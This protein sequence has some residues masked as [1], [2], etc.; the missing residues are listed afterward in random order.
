MG[1]PK[2][3]GGCRERE[4]GGDGREMR[5]KETN[6]TAFTERERQTIHRSCGGGVV[7]V[8]GALRRDWVWV[9][10]EKEGDENTPARRVSVLCNIQK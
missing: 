3:T 9:N 10:K 6:K 2:E 5:E 7:V 1:L 4:G 8:V